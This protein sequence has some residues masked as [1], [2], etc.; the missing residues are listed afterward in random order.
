MKNLADISA[1]QLRRAA[2]IREQVDA[3]A[4][5]LHVIFG[6]SADEALLGPEKPAPAVRQPRL[7]KAQIAH[8]P[9]RWQPK[10]RRKM[11]A[12]ARAKIARAARHRW[13]VARAKGRNSL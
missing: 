6:M 11:S 5:E 3:L 12:A 9:P 1:A 13:A 8:L 7:T 4:H 10:R 2:D